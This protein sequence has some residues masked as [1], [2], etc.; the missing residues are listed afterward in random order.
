MSNEDNLVPVESADK[1]SD[2]E[3][4]DTYGDGNS[5]ENQQDSQSSDFYVAPQ[6][7][8]QEQQDNANFSSKINIEE[9]YGSGV[10]ENN[11][12]QQDNTAEPLT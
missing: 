3:L 11:S 10:E 12:Q 7:Q 1:L 9:T 6:E 5:S 4:F 2:P 8:Q